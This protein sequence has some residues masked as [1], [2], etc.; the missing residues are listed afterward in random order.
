MS[1]VKCCCCAR[2]VV[3][4]SVLTFDKYCCMIPATNMGFGQWYCKECSKDL[5]EN[6]SFQEERV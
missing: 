3:S 1:I 2:Q 5:D 6:D 4:Y